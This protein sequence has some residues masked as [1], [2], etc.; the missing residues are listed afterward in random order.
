[1]RLIKKIQNPFLLRHAKSVLFIA[2]VLCTLS[3]FF[4]DIP[5]AKYFEHIS[6]LFKKGSTI[7]TDMIDPAYHYLLW[8]TLFCIF[9]FIWKKDLLAQRCFLFVIS[10]PFSNVVVE[11]IKALL[12]RP[13]PE[14]FFS[15]DLYGFTFFSL[16]N[17]Y[18]S[19][20]S[21]HACT[22]GAICGAF[23]CFYPRAALPLIAL[24]FLLAFS[25]VALNY[26]FL[27]DI[28]AGTIIG[29]LISEWVYSQI[30]SKFQ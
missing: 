20:P 28:I 21:G 23:G 7:V 6:P 18:Q 15:L 2:A 27:S 5:L 3:Y 19:F 9:R 13:R 4:I 10:I 25:R 14:L 24:A 17:V 11:T 1:M 12:G 30:D 8:P 26:H 16:A 29:I 22:A